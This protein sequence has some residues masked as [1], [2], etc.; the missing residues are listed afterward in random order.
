MNHECPH[1][2]SPRLYRA[3]NLA[4]RVIN[5]IKRCRRY[6]RLAAGCLGID[7]LASIPIWLCGHECVPW[8]DQARIGTRA[9]TRVRDSG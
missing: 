3:D 1:R 9:W 8:F 2:V 5:W 4:E 7:R 6:G